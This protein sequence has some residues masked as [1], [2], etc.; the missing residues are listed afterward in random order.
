[1]DK[2]RK[3]RRK[4]QK[5]QED[6]AAAEGQDDPAAA[7]E[8]VERFVARFKTGNY[9]CWVPQCMR[10]WDCRVSI[11]GKFNPNNPKATFRNSTAVYWYHD[12][13]R[14]RFRAATELQQIPALRNLNKMQLTH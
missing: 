12:K 4:K 3:L 13:Q 11:R 8:R 9:S 5:V 2:L 1:M 7:A 10:G 14:Q 6:P